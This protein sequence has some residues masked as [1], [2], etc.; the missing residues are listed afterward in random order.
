[1]Y[2]KQHDSLSLER[3]SRGRAARLAQW[4]ETQSLLENLLEIERDISQFNEL[5]QPLISV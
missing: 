5:S 1:M 4:T 3:S 2:L